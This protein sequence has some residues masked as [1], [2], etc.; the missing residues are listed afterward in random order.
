[1][2]LE[3]TVLQWGTDK[4]PVVACSELVHK[5]G[6][7][8]PMRVTTWLT[9]GELLKKMPSPSSWHVRPSKV[10]TSLQVWE[11]DPPTSHLKS[12]GTYDISPLLE[13]A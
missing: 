12:D 13:A 10:Q 5:V 7:S 4:N 1:M 9:K 6:Q 2:H 3:P 11:P 8:V